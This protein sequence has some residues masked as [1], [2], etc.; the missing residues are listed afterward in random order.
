M[1]DVRATVA[2]ATGHEADGV[3]ERTADEVVEQATRAVSFVGRLGSAFGDGLRDARAEH[4][5]QD[6][7]E[8]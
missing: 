8:R 6:P 2:P 7:Q 3:L 4:D 1:A 5:A